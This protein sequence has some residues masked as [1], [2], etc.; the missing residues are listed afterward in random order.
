MEPAWQLSGDFDMEAS[1]S[2]VRCC[3]VDESRADNSV[4]GV[5][6]HVEDDYNAAVTRS[7]GRYETG[8][9]EGGYSVARVAAMCRDVVR[10][11]NRLLDILANDGGEETV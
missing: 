8:P 10:S 9:P 2:T 4:G 7:T 3:G 1:A 5:S 6:G 11:T